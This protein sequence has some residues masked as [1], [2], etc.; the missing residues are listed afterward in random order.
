MRVANVIRRLKPP[1][2]V[3][4]AVLLYA[5]LALGVM[6][7]YRSSRYRSVSDLDAFIAGVVEAG[8]ALD[9]GQFPIRVAPHQLDGVQYPLFQFYANFPYTVS[10]LMFAA[11][12]N[13]YAAWRL[14]MMAAITAG[15]TF[16]FL[17]AFRLT[18]RAPASVVA[19]AAYVLAPYLFTDLNARGAIAEFF[20]LQLLPVALH[21]TLRCLSSPRKRYIPACA[22]AWT[23]VGLTHNIT[24]LYG[25]LF[26]GMFTLS[27]L[28]RPRRMPRRVARLVIAGVLHAGLMAWYVV[29]QLRVLPLLE[30][31]EQIASPTGAGA[32]TSADILFS[33]VLRSPA[34]S[35]TPNLGLQVGWTILAGVMLAA[36]GV[37]VARRRRRQRFLRR[38]T[39]RLVALFAI[40]LVMAWS[41]LGV[42]DHVPRLLWFIQFPYRLLGY[43]TLLGALL[44]ACGLALCLRGRPH[45]R[46]G[47]AYFVALALIGA[48]A[49]S[50]FPRARLRYPNFV[51]ETLASPVCM[52]LNDY[53]LSGPATAATGYAHPDVDLS[54]PAFGLVQSNAFVIGEV[55]E[56]AAAGL[57]IPP[58]ATAVRLR[59]SA[60]NAGDG[61]PP[62]RLE[63]KLGHQQF[64]REMPAGKFD[65][66][67]P[68]DPADGPAQGFTL[69][70]RDH[71]GRHVRML[72][73]SAR[74]EGARQPPGRRLIVAE[75]VAADVRR[76]RNVRF[77]FA[78]D[79][80]VLLQLP[81][82][83]YPGMLRLRDNGNAV[84][85][86][87]VGR[88]V[89]VELPP[90]LICMTPTSTVPIA[91][92]EPFDTV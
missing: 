68:I 77:R 70:P 52:G 69:T 89:A 42:W 27:M 51:R 91:V 57:D 5:A 62:E 41:P 14:A 30:V 24:Y 22:V 59:G 65:F 55:R 49:I 44:A 13:P 53:L 2:S 28:G 61:Q 87:N 15:G 1:P 86:A 9:D 63:V 11:G 20:A 35:S 12:M 76:G 50:Y 66:V 25:A 67:F 36:L 34:G 82:L 75:D 72:L 16:T 19:G 79:D 60:E 18:R 7:P 54:R 85:F 92:S 29:P 47:W 78:C 48:G 6:W 88:Y 32:L 58:G 31:R 80:P 10:G 4:G 8:N 38:V 56:H 3:V 43:T 45:S 40:A 84:P 74:Y 64:V 90:A 39:V 23:L 81:V 83:Y 21:A 17:A 37:L 73:S 26:V 33:P 71:V 46:G